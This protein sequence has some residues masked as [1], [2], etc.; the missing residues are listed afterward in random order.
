[1]VEPPTYRVN[2]LESLAVVQRHGAY[3]LQGP[4][5]TRCREQGTIRA[6]RRPAKKTWASKRPRPV[7]KSSAWVCFRF[8]GS[9]FSCFSRV[10]PVRN[11]TALLRHPQELGPCQ[12]M[13]LSRLNTLGRCRRSLISPR[14]RETG[15]LL[16]MIF[17]LR[18]LRHQDDIPSP[19]TG[20][21]NMRDPP[22]HRRCLRQFTSGN[23]SRIEQA[24]DDA[25]PALQP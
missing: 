9:S 12:T 2:P 21:E 3:G 18:N 4:I 14:A 6:A 17:V 19:R 5:E 22:L 20:A 1:M 15:L 8:R 11:E 16:V 13:K 10:P 25:M 24:V 23:S 7:P